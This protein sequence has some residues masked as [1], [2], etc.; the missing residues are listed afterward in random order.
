MNGLSAG[1]AA[2]VITPRVGVDLSGYAARPGPSVGVHDELWCRALVLDDGARRVA[3]AAL[4]LLGVDLELD[5][6]IREATSAYLPPDHLLINCS[7]THAG[8]SVTRLD[9]RVAADRGYVSS[10][11]RRIAEVVKEA[12]SRLTPAALSYGSA[13][14]RI[15]INRR[16]RTPDGQII[17]GRSPEGIVDQEMRALRISTADGDPIAVLFHHACHGTT[18]GGENLLI[19]ADWM[20]AACACLEQRTGVPALFLQGCAGQTNPDA[21]ERSFEE[22][23]RLGEMA[24]QAVLR[25]LAGAEPIAGAPLAARRGK[26]ALP[27]QDPPD[28]K[29]ARAGLAAAEA[30]AARAR[31]EG[32]HPY[33]VQALESC[34]PLARRIVE[35]ADRG[36]GGLTLPFAVQAMRMGDLALVGLSGEVFLEFGRRIAAAS[37]FPHTWALGYSNGCECYVPTPEAFAEGGYEAAD[38]FRWYGTLPLAP[39]A[40][41]R[42]ADE[43]VRMLTQ[44]TG[45][46]AG[47]CSDAA[48]E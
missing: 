10:L 40:G 20:G 4:D 19:S 39:D 28:P 43:A 32:A 41:E 29:Q 17:I 26:I 45:E 8:P 25:A 27:L 13:P 15:G 36:A 34:L 47:N 2:A 18:L 30:A 1:A 22:V 44:V 48:G 7:H 9:R 12:A 35:L 42:M 38:S 16:E 46:A 23:A 5:A 31:S 3:I 37:P 24:C 14:A 33:W 21:Q 11:P 6:A